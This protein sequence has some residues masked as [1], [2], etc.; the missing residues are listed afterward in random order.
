MTYR[1][2]QLR[3]R[4]ENIISHLL[5]NERP[6]LAAWAISLMFEIILPLIPNSEINNHVDLIDII[7]EGITTGLVLAYLFFIIRFFRGKS[8]KNNQSPFIPIPLTWWSYLWRGMFLLWLLMYFLLI[9]SLLIS[10]HYEIDQMSLFSP[11]I[12]IPLAVTFIPIFSF[13]FFAVERKEKFIMLVT[14]L[15]LKR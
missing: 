8:N 1:L 10:K 7:Q 2:L 14:F 6:V 9:S 4:F 11:I 5:K 12:S 15:R 13:I 3:I